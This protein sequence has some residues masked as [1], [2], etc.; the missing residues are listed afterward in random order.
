MTNAR[1]ANLQGIAN[2]VY[3]GVRCPIRKEEPMNRAEEMEQALN[4]VIEKIE[5][6]RTDGD[7]EHWQYSQLFDIVDNALAMPKRQCDVGTAEEQDR[8]MREFCKS[9]FDNSIPEKHMC[10]KCILRHKTHNCT[11]AWSQML[12]ERE[13]PNGNA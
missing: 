10:H 11:I 3:S 8:R 12:Y 7:M 4:E 6:W 5:K 9:Q 2:A 13:V 1:S